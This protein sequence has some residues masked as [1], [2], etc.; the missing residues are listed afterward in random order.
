MNLNNLLVLGNIEG[1]IEYYA[2]LKPVLTLS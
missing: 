1:G 2:R